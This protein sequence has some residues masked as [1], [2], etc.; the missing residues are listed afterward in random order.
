MPR[1][2]SFDPPEQIEEYRILRPLG[3]GAMGRVFLAHD[4]LLDR[5]VAIKFI[6]ELDPQQLDPEGMGLR[7]RFFIEARAIARLHHPN[8]VLVYRVGEWRGRPFLVSELVR[9]TALDKLPLPVPWT[10]VLEIGLGLCRG[11]AAAHRQG[12]LHRDIKPANAMQTR[13][14]EL[15]LL[16]F[17]LAKLMTPSLALAAQSMPSVPALSAA[18]LAADAAPGGEL[19]ATQAARVRGGGRAAENTQAVHSRLVEGLRP[20]NPLAQAPFLAAPFSLTNPR[21]PQFHQPTTRACARAAGSLNS[22][23]FRRANAGSDA[24]GVLECCVSAAYHA[25]PW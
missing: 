10:R 7:E 23:G 25:A 24:N 12:V 6:A 13:D 18:V 17:G 21:F 1:A 11:L 16:D 2:K 4:T 20:D 9:G 15:K 19:V 8:V 3:Q 14:G 22:L 5:P